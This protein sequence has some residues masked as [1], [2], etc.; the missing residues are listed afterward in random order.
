MI[1]THFLFHIYYII[2]KSLV[3]VQLFN[4]NIVFIDGEQIYFEKN[5]P[6]ALL[7]YP[8]KYISYNDVFLIN[9]LSFQL[10]CLKFVSVTDDKQQKQKAQK[11]S[12][13]LNS[14]EPQVCKWKIFSNSIII[15]IQLNEIFVLKLII[16][17]Y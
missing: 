4:G 10:M 2:D 3:C 17:N 11:S 8:I 9:T 1:I 14:L 16:N 15:F 7:Y 6:N 5:L 12:F 13:K